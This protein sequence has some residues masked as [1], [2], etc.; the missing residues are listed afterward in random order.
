MA[1]DRVTVDLNVRE[2]S[3]RD[4]LRVD[5]ACAGQR[6]QRA[7]ELLAE[8]LNF[9]QVRSENLDADRRLD[10]GQQHIEPIA[11]RLRPDIRESWKLQLGVHISLKF[12]E[13]HARTPLL[14]RLQRDGGVHHA[15]RRVIGGRRASTDRPEHRFHF[16]KRPQ[17]LVL[18]LQQPRGFGD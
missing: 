15:H 4:A 14:A 5:A 12:F 16:G 18:H 17:N 11:D 7:L 1:R 3:L 13:R 8:P 9:V 10:A 2:I 6:L